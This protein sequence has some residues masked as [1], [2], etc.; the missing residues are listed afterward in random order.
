[1]NKTFKTHSD[2]VNYLTSKTDVMDYSSGRNGGER[3]LFVL[4]GDGVNNKIVIYT[5][6]EEDGGWVMIERYS[7]RDMP[8]IVGCPERILR[9]ST[10]TNL[11]AAKWRVANRNDYKI[12]QSARKLRENLKTGD[13][14]FVENKDRLDEPLEAE[15]V[16][17]RDSKAV[18]RL[19][20]FNQ[21][22]QAAVDMVAVTISDLNELRLRRSVR[23]DI[24]AA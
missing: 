16:T 12:S 23:A 11:D 1:M 22:Y 17:M 21:L 8:N 24:L 18:Y 4:H 2:L 20:G 10:D 9:M 5:L 13:I 3:R 14:I 6:A 15:F 19:I 7:E